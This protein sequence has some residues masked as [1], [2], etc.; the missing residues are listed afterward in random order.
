[1][2]ARLD[3]LLPI[4]DQTLPALLN[5]LARARAARRRAG[6]LGR[7]V[8]PHAADQFQRRPRPLAAVLLRGRWPAAARRRDSSTAPA[9]SSARTRRVGQARPEDLA[10]TMF[11]ALGID[12]E[13][14]IRDKLNRPL[15][16]A[17]G[18]PINEVFA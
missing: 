18:K 16:I 17:R 1:M 15:P 14:E 12:P 13:T 6:G 7:R 4:T 11:E 2:P 3:E 9:T 5:D 10:A 8:R